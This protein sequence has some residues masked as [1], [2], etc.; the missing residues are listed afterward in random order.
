MGT[1]LALQHVE[2]GSDVATGL[3][4]QHEE[5]GSD[6]KVMWLRA[7]EPNM[8]ETENYVSNVTTAGCLMDIYQ[9]DLSFLSLCLSYF[10]SFSLSLSMLDHICLVPSPRRYLRSTIP[11][12][13]NKDREKT[14]TKKQPQSL[15]GNQR[16]N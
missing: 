4:L 14:T 5:T 9:R 7:L 15:M 2:T 12:K 6:F 16:L 3:A 13:Q 10:L 11:V 1:G 8:A